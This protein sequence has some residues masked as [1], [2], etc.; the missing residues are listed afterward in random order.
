MAD[1]TNPFAKVEVTVGRLV[2]VTVA[3]GAFLAAIVVAVALFTY[4]TQH[5][6]CTFRDD[7]QSR[8]DGTHRFLRENPQG[9]PGVPNKLIRT[10]VAGQE[11]TLR[12]LRGLWC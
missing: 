8:V 7:L 4:R 11:A 9:I 5:A 1:E 10:Q 3:L 12:S 6:L 2:W